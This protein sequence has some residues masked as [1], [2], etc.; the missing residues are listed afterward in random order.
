MTMKMKRRILYKYLFALTLSFIVS[1]SVWANDKSVSLREFSL[2]GGLRQEHFSDIVQDRKGYIYIGTWDGIVRYD[3]YRFDSFRPQSTTVETYRVLKMRLGT[4]DNIYCEMYNGQIYVFDTKACRFIPPLES[5]PENWARANC[6]THCKEKKSDGMIKTLYPKGESYSVD[7]SGNIW[8]RGS[9]TLAL[10]SVY[11]NCYSKVKPGNDMFIRSVYEDA[12]KQIWQGSKGGHLI[13]GDKFMA[14]DGTLTSDKTRFTDK[15][16]YSICQDKLGRMLIGTRGDGLYRLTKMAGRFKV[17]HKP[18]ESA[19]I[20]DIVCDGNDNYH[21]ATWGRGIIHLSGDEWNSN[22]TAKLRR[23]LTYDNMMLAASTS[24]LLVYL[25]NGR[26]HHLLPGCDITFIAIHDGTLYLSI[27]G[28]GLYCMKTDD[29]LSENPE[30]IEYAVTENTMP[31]AISSGILIEDDMW[32]LSSRSIIR[33]S[34]KDTTVSSLCIADCLHTPTGD[35]PSASA[36]HFS[37]TTPAMLSDKRIIVGTETGSI[38]IDTSDSTT[39]YHPSPIVVTGIKYQGNADIT[40]V[41][42][43][44]TLRI[45]PDERSFALFISTLDIKNAQHINFLYKTDDIDKEWNYLSQANSI[46]FNGIRPETYSLHIKAVSVENRAHASERTIIIEV[47]PRF[48]ETTLFH[49]II[50]LLFGLLF[51]AATYTVI[52]VRNMHRR[53]KELE[54]YCNQLLAEQYKT[55][56]PTDNKDDLTRTS[57]KVSALATSLSTNDNNDKDV[58]DKFME[59]FNKYMADSDKTLDDYAQAMNMSYSSLYRKM[60]DMVGCTPVEFITRLRI[61]VAVKIL[62][63]GETPISDVA[64]RV[65][66]NDPKYFSKRFKAKIGMTPSQYQESVS[67]SK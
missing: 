6:F 46:N 13:Y 57:D 4:D 36:L 35:V 67:S 43:A 54:L 40:P 50:V 2:T 51:G 30:L 10:M 3:G 48:Y 19:N 61:E 1:I 28:K 11:D 62:E 20:Y 58:L 42:D 55:D 14:P 9:R 27:Y 64:Y 22:G 34:L 25:Q 56:K 60:K 38:I 23:I 7:R 24:G 5:T 32:L 31:K 29:L 66:F 37:E 52:Y 65:G 41:Y 45:T 53:Q 63:Q 12:E 26:T 17:E 59:V 16:I 21:L 15:G 47:E 49:A 44:D 8:I 39:S 18:L 33:L